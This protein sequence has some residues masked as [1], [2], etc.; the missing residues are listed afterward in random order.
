MPLDDSSISKEPDG[1]FN[2]DYCKWCYADGNFVYTNLD[3]LISFL[4]EHMSNNSWPA[5][6]A[7]AFFKE[8]L[9]QLDY[10]NKKDS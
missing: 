1:T 4:V 6:Q 3:E 7:K 10:W 9:P 8:Q 2:E 5:E